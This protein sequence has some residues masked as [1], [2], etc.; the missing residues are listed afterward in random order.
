MSLL[1]EQSNT[2]TLNFKLPP[3]FEVP[4]DGA[5]ETIVNV[6]V[7]N[8]KSPITVKDW[9]HP[10]FF[11][12]A[13]RFNFPHN[14]SGVGVKYQVNIQ[15]FHNQQPLLVELDYFVVVNQAPYAQTVNLSPI[16]MLYIEVKV[17]ETLPAEEAI[18]ISLHEAAAPEVE[19]VSIKQDEQTA[20][21]FYLKYDPDSVIPGKRYALTGI[22]NRYHQHVQ[23]SPGPVELSPV[24]RNARARLFQSV[25]L[26][27]EKPLRLFTDANAKIR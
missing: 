22:E 7:V 13:W 6:K 16:G 21:S 11:G 23:V 1:Y 18:T 15:M 24:S 3:E 4:L 8:A 5:N 2:V 19:L 26:W 14:Y 12:N 27:L 10:A 9:R 17:P 20:T 25:A